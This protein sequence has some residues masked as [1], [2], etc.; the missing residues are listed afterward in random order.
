MKKIIFFDFL[1]ENSGMVTW[2][3]VLTLLSFFQGDLFWMCIL[4]YVFIVR[5]FYSDFFSEKIKKK[6]AGAIWI[7]SI[8]LAISIYYVNSQFSHGEMYE[9]GEIVCLNDERGPCG[10]QMREDLR[11]LDN[12]SWAIFL[13]KYG[14]ILIMALVIAGLTLIDTKKS[15]EE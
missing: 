2:T 3:I 10:E 4:V 9:T 1:K 11:G 7:I 5:I 6:I 8:I 13:K 12:P 14:L 15:L